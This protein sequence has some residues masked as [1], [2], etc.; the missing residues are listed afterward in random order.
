[1]TSTKISAIKRLELH[2]L[3]KYKVTRVRSEHAF[4]NK[5]ISFVGKSKILTFK[6]LKQHTTNSLDVIN[7][8]RNFFDNLKFDGRDFQRNIVKL[9]FIRPDKMEMS[10]E[11]GKYIQHIEQVFTAKGKLGNDLI[12]SVKV[13]SQNLP[14]GKAIGWRGPI[15]II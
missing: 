11:Q 6:K 8:H 7:L 5:L 2:F 12:K 10:S 14:D 4:L 1:M 3:K 15:F 13:K 9:K